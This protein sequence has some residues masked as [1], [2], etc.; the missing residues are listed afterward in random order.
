MNEIHQYRLQI[1]TGGDYVV[2]RYLGTR[3]WNVRFCKSPDEAAAVIRRLRQRLPRKKTVK[4]KLPKRLTK[5][6]Q[7]SVLT[8]TTSSLK[9]AWCGK[10]A[11]KFLAQHPHCDGTHSRTKVGMDIIAM[12]YDRLRRAGWKVVRALEA[13]PVLDRKSVPH[14]GM[15]DV[16][17]AC[18]KLRRILQEG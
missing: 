17:R 3:W 16:A 8:K 14:T 10:P 6:L 2:Q 13:I 12:R 7:K 11:K 18:D 1:R 9:C 4:K 15:Q 5:Q